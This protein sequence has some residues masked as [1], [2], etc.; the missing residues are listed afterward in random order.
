M[1]DFCG[2]SWRKWRDTATDA[3]TWKRMYKE[4]IDTICETWGLPLLCSVKDGPPIVKAG[5]AASLDWPLEELPH[6]NDK[7]WSTS[8][9][10]FVVLM[11]SQVIQRI[12]CGYAAL[13]D[14]HF[15]PNFQRITDIIMMLNNEI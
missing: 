15:R 7:V 5:E 12:G 13:A 14:D 10:R 11:D 8:G 4:I 1:V 9:E 6:P 3:A 2:V